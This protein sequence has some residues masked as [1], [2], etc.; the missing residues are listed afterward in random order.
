MIGSC[1]LSGENMP[2]TEMTISEAMKL[3]DS[4]L[5]VT[6]GSNHKWLVWDEVWAEWKVYQQAYQ[7]KFARKVYEGV[8]Q[9][10]AITELLKDE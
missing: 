1:R 2:I 10:D 9:A 5:R 6:N 7:Q 3:E 8:S 4:P